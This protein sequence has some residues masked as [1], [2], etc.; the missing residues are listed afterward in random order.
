MERIKVT[1][2]PQCGD[3]PEVEVME[4]GVRIGEGANTVQLTHAQWNDLI[5]RIR[6][7]ELT[8]VR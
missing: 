2:C 7:G 8:E 6:S 5:A 4:S 3:C 1:L